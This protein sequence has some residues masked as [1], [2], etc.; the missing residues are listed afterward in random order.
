MSVVEH[1]G[2]VPFS[3]VTVPDGTAV[4]DATFTVT[5][6]CSDFS[7]LTPTDD[8][9]SATAVVV[10]TAVPRHALAEVEPVR[11]LV[12][13]PLGHAVGAAAPGL[14]TYVPAGAGMQVA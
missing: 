1:N 8:A 14:E 13:V 11:P 3:T 7:E 9:D 5:V 6:N 10:F 2:V 12:V 4:P